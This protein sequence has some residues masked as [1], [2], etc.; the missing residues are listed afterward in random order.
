MKTI[1]LPLIV[2]SA[3]LSVAG[4]AADLRVST[5]FE[6]G[7]AKVESIDQTASVIRFMP[8]GDPQRVW[9]CWWYL[10]VDGVAKDERVTLSLA[11]SDRPTRNNGQDTGKPLAA[12]WAMPAR[13]TFSTDGKSWQ[14]TAPGERDGARILYEVI[15]TGGPVWVAWGPPFTPKDTDALLA[16]AEKS[17]SAA[18]A[19]ELAKT[20]GGRPVRGLRVSEATAS[21]P[22]GIWV[23]A[24]QHRSE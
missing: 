13:A 8:G 4:F 21:K 15:G 17:S 22:P 1:G 5:D 3:A 14:H 7:S 12:G 11:G 20:R 6:G 9:P 23:H 19:F 24:R 18:K 2:M 16:E 10:R